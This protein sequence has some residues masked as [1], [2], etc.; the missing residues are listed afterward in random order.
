MIFHIVYEDLKWVRV[1]V[2]KK[3]HGAKFYTQ[4]HFR[5]KASEIMVS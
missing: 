3:I 1:E 4:I 2:I 5:N